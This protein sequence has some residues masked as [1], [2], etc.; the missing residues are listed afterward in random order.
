MPHQLS[1]LTRPLSERKQWKAKEWENF[2]LYY[3]LPL[4]ALFVSHKLYT[5]WRCFVDSLFILLKDKIIYQ[6]LDKADEMLHDFVYMTQ[7]YF[8]KKAMTFNIH[9]LLH[10]A[11]SVANWGPLFDHSTFPFEAANHH[12]LQAIHCAK[13]VNLQI[14]RFINIQRVTYAIERIVYPTASPMVKDYCGQAS[15]R[16]A[17]NCLKISNITYLGKGSI[18]LD[19]MYNSLHLPLNST[20]L[21]FR[22]IKDGCLYASENTNNKRSNN[23]YAQLRDGR[24]IKIIYFIVNVDLN[25]ELTVLKNVKTTHELCNSIVYV[26]TNEN[27]WITSVVNTSEIKSIC[28]FMK[29]GDAS[30]ICQLPN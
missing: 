4:F 29:V 10:L 11:T 6:E 20:L 3:S 9:Q 13:G 27:N 8:T 5:Y 1:R 25:T 30:Y 26:D 7:K 16:T 17:K 2:I 15:I 22:A 12:L 19:A 23:S 24:Y 28:V 21:F 14:A 18:L